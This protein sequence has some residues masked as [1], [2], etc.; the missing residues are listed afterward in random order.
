MV[1][2]MSRSLAQGFTSRPLRA[3]DPGRPSSWRGNGCPATDSGTVFTNREHWFEKYDCYGSAVKPGSR[4]PPVPD[5]FPLRNLPG[6]PRFTSQRQVACGAH[7]QDEGDLTCRGVEPTGWR[8]VRTL[9]PV[10]LLLN[11]IQQQGTRFG[12]MP[13]AVFGVTFRARGRLWARRRSALL[14]DSARDH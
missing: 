11:P 6:L 4:E 1:R 13:S 9:P 2:S 3:G 10:R 5:T 7:V 8:A 12:H 14:A